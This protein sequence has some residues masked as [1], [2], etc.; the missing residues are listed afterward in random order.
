LKHCFKEYLSNFITENKKRRIEEVLEKRTRYV[1]VV[2]EDIFKPHNASAVLRTVDCFG[3][4]D[5]HVIEN[6]NQYKV[7]PYV[8]R[9]ASQWVDLLRYREKGAENTKRC[10]E[11]LKERGFKI[12][13]T[14]P[15]AEGILPEEINLDHKVALA[16]GNEH[17]GLSSEA[18]EY[19]DELV[20]LPMHGFTESYNISVTASICLYDLV[21]RLHASEIHWKITEDE[22]EDLRMK[23]YR[24]VV[25][26]IDIHE[27]AYLN[28]QK[29]HDVKEN[30]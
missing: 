3:L 10:Y 8:T 28:Q 4:Q 27:K 24:R 19:A 30:N 9:G 1:T 26:R 16:L 22:K 15:N 6:N 20:R 25:K 5:V 18:I 13:A 14:T 17:T 21:K 7:N 12:Y 23:W 2:L 29:L 11:S